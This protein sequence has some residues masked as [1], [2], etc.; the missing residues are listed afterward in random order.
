[1]R[2][3]RNVIAGVPICWRKVLQ[4][5]P[6]EQDQRQYPKTTPQAP[7]TGEK[8]CEA[9][10][11]F[12]GHGI[13]RMQPGGIRAP[14]IKAHSLNGQMALGGILWIHTDGHGFTEAEHLRR[15]LRANHYFPQPPW[16]NFL[17]QSVLTSHHAVVSL[18][19]WPLERREAMKVILNAV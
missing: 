2:L 7:P 11:T 16:T 5:S 8:S 9:R 10:L 4:E 14:F 1:M 19:P 18:A 3:D 15:I 13:S 6:R 17:G 12:F